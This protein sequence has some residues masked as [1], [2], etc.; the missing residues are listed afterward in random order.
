MKKL[1]FSILA[2]GMSL[3]G[4]TDWDDAVSENYG[5]G[6]EIS[7]SVA[8]TADNSFSFTLTPSNG[9]QF[10]SYVVGKGSEASELDGYSLLKQQY[11]G[12]D[13]GLLNAAE[14][15]TATIEVEASPNTSYVVYAV[16]AN[17]KGIV[18]NVTSQVIKTTDSGIPAPA[19]AKAVEGEAAVQVAFS[20]VISR[21]TGAVTAQYFVEWTGEFVDIAAEDITVEVSG[22][23]VTF[24]FANVPA[25]ATVLVSWAEGAF[26]D[27]AGNKCQA[28][29]SGLN[30]AGTAFA[31]VY[32]NVADVPFDINVENITSPEVG[33]SFQDAANTIFTFTFDMNVYRN[34]KLLQ[35]GEIKVHYSHSGK[36]TTL[37]V[38]TGYWATKGNT[39]L[40][41]LPEEPAYGD[42]VS[43]EI[44]EG[45]I[46]DQYGNPNRGVF[47]TDCWLYSYGYKREMVIGGYEVNYYG[48]NAYTAGSWVNSTEYIKIE[49]DSETEDGIIMTGF[50]GTET[51]VYATFD[52]DFATITMQEQKIAT[53]TLSDGTEV[54][55]TVGGN[56]DDGSLVFTVN[57]DGSFGY[58]DGLGFFY[59]VYNATTGDYMGYF[60]GSIYPEFTKIVVARSLGLKKDVERTKNNFTI[61]RANS[62]LVK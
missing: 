28:F 9:T 18:G 56:T 12:V 33:G 39:V 7:V 44:S 8:A 32:F 3:T 38:P 14:N 59:W 50:Y 51:P 48:Y 35:G 36:T 30:S 41:M 2:I 23:V 55:V 42:K 37:E 27:N 49:A 34:T 46:F 1:L 24:K 22:N 60:E 26:V 47:F 58:Y 54:I 4:C 29:N 11:S 17:D 5:A 52:G 10:Y 31:G 20:E 15:A 13:G 19:S 6:P 57:E 21:G 53:A 45:I 62:K 25:S 40:V 61:V 43:L 16:A